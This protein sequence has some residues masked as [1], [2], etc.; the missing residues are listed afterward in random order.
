M[1]TKILC[2]FELEVCVKINSKM[3]RSPQY[4]VS[5]VCVKEDN[6]K[7]QSTACIYIGCSKEYTGS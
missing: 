2:K 5:H 1:S 3:Y 7:L 6:K 4:N